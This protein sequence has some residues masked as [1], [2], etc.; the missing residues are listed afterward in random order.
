[1]P[2]QHQ[3]EV[4]TENYVGA[5][6]DVVDL[7][8]EDFAYDLYLRLS[9][10]TGLSR[11]EFHDIYF[12]Q[13]GW[14]DAR[15]FLLGVY[16]SCGLA[17]AAQAVEQESESSITRADY[18]TYQKVRRYYA[19]LD[20][21]RVCNDREYFLSDELR[22]RIV[23]RY[24]KYQGDN[25]HWYPALMGFIEDAIG[26]GNGFEVIGDGIRV[27][28]VLQLHDIYDNRFDVQKVAFTV[29]NTTA[30]TLSV[31]QLES[32]LDDHCL[33][34]SSDQTVLGTVVFFAFNQGWFKPPANW[35]WGDPLEL[36]ADTADVSFYLDQARRRYASAHD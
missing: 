26:D 23:D 1:M 22:E 9:G 5:V 4:R 36:T 19:R 34:E 10:D 13:G 8:F 14:G 3:A 27:S 21:L 12:L 2:D 33:Y 15:E 16:K 28:G 32:M 6:G 29:P 31:D 18:L 30:S 11:D 25:P 17:A 24:D 35:E 20:V 7:E